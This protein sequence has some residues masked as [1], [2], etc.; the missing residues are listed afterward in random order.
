[1]NERMVL[2]L[3][4]GMVLV[5]I[6][7]SMGLAL[8]IVV[9]LRR[10]A[11]RPL[12]SDMEGVTVVP[13]R[14]LA[15]TFFPFGSSENSI[16]PRLEVTRDSLRFKVFKVDTWPFS[17]LQ[18]VDAPWLPL[19]TRIAFTGKAGRSLLVD[20]ADAARARELLMLLP[21]DLAFTQRAAD[22][23]NGRA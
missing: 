8:W 9:K 10:K 16:S 23:R 4:V 20:V 21:R 11:D 2:A 1:M 5:V 14:R 13:V 7:L 19:T 6:P 12:S 22:L 3:V 15:R 18:R 17:E